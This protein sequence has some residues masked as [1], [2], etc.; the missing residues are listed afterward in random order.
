MVEPVD[1]PVVFGVTEHRLDRRLPFPVELFAEFCAEHS[2]H[3]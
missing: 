2:S 3:E 1:L